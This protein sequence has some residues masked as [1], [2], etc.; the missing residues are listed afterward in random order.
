MLQ[1][2]RPGQLL[3]QPCDRGALGDWAPGSR[4]AVPVALTA[5]PAGAKREISHGLAPR[6]RAYLEFARIMTRNAPAFAK[7]GRDAHIDRHFF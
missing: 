1:S 3:G 6:P 4:R 7:F 5:G 2:I